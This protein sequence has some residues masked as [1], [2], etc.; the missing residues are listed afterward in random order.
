MNRIIDVPLTLVSAY[1]S[2]E[3]VLGIDYISRGDVE[4]LAK[5]KELNNFINTLRHLIEGLY[6]ET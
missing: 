2:V 1:K 6:T 3:L 4:E 5:E